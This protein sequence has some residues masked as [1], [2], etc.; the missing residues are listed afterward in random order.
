MCDDRIAQLW[1]EGAL[2]EVTFQMWSGPQCSGQVYPAVD[3]DIQ[4][5][6]PARPPF[7]QVQSM[8]IPPH[9]R[10]VVEDRSKGRVIE[11]QG[12][13]RFV[14]GS[15]L[16][17]WP[18]KTRV[19]GRD[20]V[21]SVDLALVR[22]RPWTEWVL[23]Q[24]MRVSLSTTAPIESGYTYTPLPG[25]TV[26]M[27]YESFYRWYCGGPG[28]SDRRCA[29]AAR[30]LDRRDMLDHVDTL[31]ACN[32]GSPV[33]FVPSYVRRD[34]T[35]LDNCS[36]ALFNMSPSS[37]SVTTVVC[38]SHEFS[39]RGEVSVSIS[40]RLVVD[41]RTAEKEEEISDATTAW[42]VVVLLG[43]PLVLLLAM[44]LYHNLIGMRRRQSVG[45]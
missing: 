28:A 45:E 17:M 18:D 23:D 44:V 12:L 38:G 39:S 26:P 15:P 25:L 31:T 1:A 34:K 30:T 2:A 22:D 4:W 21:F 16:L 27:F 24:S 35:T 20:L 6:V 11:L 7:P 5:P 40:E 8:Y 37:T 3:G 13:I 19:S 10:L 29:C 32:S 42:I 41:N 33:P 43:V 14:D 36:Q 9:A